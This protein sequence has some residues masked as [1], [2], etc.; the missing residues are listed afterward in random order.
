[1]SG[2]GNLFTAGLLPREL[3]WDIPGKAQGYTEGDKSKWHSCANADFCHANE[4]Q[5]FSGSRMV[6]TEIRHVFAPAKR[7]SDRDLQEI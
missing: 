3:V 7:P 4:E 1:M 6:E 5:C 2:H